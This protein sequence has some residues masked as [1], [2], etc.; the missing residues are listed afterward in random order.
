MN[1]FLP[2]PHDSVLQRDI[3]RRFLATPI[4]VSDHELAQIFCMKRSRN[5]D[6]LQK[7]PVCYYRSWSITKQ[8][9]QTMIK[10]LKRNG[11]NFPQLESWTSQLRGMDEHERVWIRYVGQ[12]TS[13]TPFQRCAKSTKGPKARAILSNEFKRHYEALDLDRAKDVRVFILCDTATSWLFKKCTSGLLTRSGGRIADSFERFL[14]TLFGSSSL[15]NTQAG[16]YR[17]SFNPSTSDAILLSKIG[18]TLMHTVSQSVSKNM[19]PQVKLRLS[20]I[21]ETIC[22]RI[23]RKL[24]KGELMEATLQYVKTHYVEQAASETFHDHCIA[25]IIGEAVTEQAIRENTRFFDGSSASR[26][27]IVGYLEECLACESSFSTSSHLDDLLRLLSF[28]NVF[29]W[30]GQP[31]RK[32]DSEVKVIQNHDA[33]PLKNTLNPTNVSHYKIENLAHPLGRCCAIVDNYA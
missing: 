4:T 29:H 10:D 22:D 23:R 33:A 11:F 8:E 15:L 17:L 7:G 18:T 16:G 27:A 30:P 32:P 19:D 20:A 28:T 14:I 21:T 31:A 1:A 24:P 3:F 26:D 5:S 9:L 13:F 25:V 6:G 2:K 12:T